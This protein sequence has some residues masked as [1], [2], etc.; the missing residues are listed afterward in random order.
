MSPGRLVGP[1]PVMIWSLATHHNLIATEA[2]MP[3]RA[4]GEIML[5]EDH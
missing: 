1:F 4:K 5:L 3:A 2:D